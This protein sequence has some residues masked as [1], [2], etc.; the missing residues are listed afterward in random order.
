MKPLSITRIVEQVTTGRSSA[1]RIAADTLA[2]ATEYDAIQPQVWISR[3]PREEVLARARAVDAQVASGEKLPL[4]GVPIAVKDNIDVA[5][6]ETT[7]ACPAFAYRPQRSAIVIQRLL[8]AGAVVIGKTNLD[9]FAT[10]L[11]GTRSPFGALGCVFNREYISGGSS[12]G[13][14]IAVAAGIVPLGIGTDTAGSGRV[15]AAF[16]GLVGFKP[17]RGRWSTRGLVPACRSLDCAN[18]FTVTSED[19]RRVDAVLAAFDTADPYSRHPASATRESPDRFR[20]GIG[21]PAQLAFLG[22]RQSAA[23]YERAVALAREVGGCL[24]EVD[25]Q[26]FLD[27]GQ[28]LYAGPWVAER[29][30][31]LENLL[32]SNPSAIHPDV[33]AIVQAGKGVLAVDAY[34]G[35]HA[36]QTH[37][38][39]A[40]TL[41]DRCEMLLLPTVAT[42]YRISEMLADSIS[43]NANLGLY[44]SF[45]NLLDMCAVAV[46]TGVRSNRTGF[47]VSLV[48]PAWSDL[49]LLEFAGRLEIARGTQEVPPLD[50][51]RPRTSVLV[52]VVGA[53]LSGMPLHWQLTSRRARLVQRTRT[54]RLY[55][56]YAMRGEMP[57]KPA[58][59]HVGA[60]G[61]QIE[62]EVYELG[63]GEFGSLTAEVPP[64]LAIGTIVLEDGSSVKGFVAEPRALDGATDITAKG[65]WRAFLSAP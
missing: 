26:P 63:V 15:P 38:R 39:A 41:W 27:A 19:A 2:R 53:H 9:Q 54:A 50:L 31:V 49:A 29:T 7:A 20:V 24:V 61:G 43:L 4:A 58:L 65:G 56:L 35:A 8:A 21:R 64:P 1:E 11:A 22:D 10:G 34:R 33:R 62:L 32:A 3:F 16:N 46:S 60:G 36:L 47:G 37:A 42:T 48:G 18:A 5:G 40:A 30:M 6:L 23:H 14:A 17:T 45:V 44:T 57:Q 52:A 28:L 13:S 51:S 59:V 55:R 25:I 12:S